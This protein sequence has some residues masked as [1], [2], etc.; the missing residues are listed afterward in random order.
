VLIAV[1]LKALQVGYSCHN[2]HQQVALV[3]AACMTRVAT[4]RAV[5]RWLEPGQ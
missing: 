5:S 2:G 4:V 3:F 1:S